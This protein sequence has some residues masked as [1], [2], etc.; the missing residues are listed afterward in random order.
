MRPSK[1]LDVAI[2]R[3]G[4]LAGATVSGALLVAGADVASGTN[5]LAAPPAPQTRYPLY[6][7]PTVGLGNSYNLDAAPAT[8]DLGGGNLSSVL[9]YNGT[10]PGPSFRGRPGET[11]LITL[12]NQLPEETITH[13]HGMI[14]DHENDGHPVYAIPPGTTV[15]V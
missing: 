3:R 14:V 6:V 7:P 13:W 11:A 4:F 1:G 2:S 9:A 8:V 15:R 5:A 10:M 12:G